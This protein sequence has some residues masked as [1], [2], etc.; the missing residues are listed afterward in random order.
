MDQKL[1]ITIDESL[2]AEH[3]AMAERSLR[4]AIEFL[5]NQPRPKGLPPIENYIPN[6]EEIK[7]V[8]GGDTWAHGLYS[9][10]TM[11]GWCVINVRT[12]GRLVFDSPGAA[13]TIENVDLELATTV[14][15]L[16]MLDGYYYP[17]IDWGRQFHRQL[18]YVDSLAATDGRAKSLLDQ[19]EEH[20][21]QQEQAEKDQLYQQQWA[22]KNRLYF[23]RRKERWQLRL[24]S[25]WCTKWI[26]HPICDVPHDTNRSTQ[27]PTQE[28]FKQ[29]QQPVDL[30]PTQKPQPLELEDI[31]VGDH[32][33]ATSSWQ[34][35][36]DAALNTEESTCDT[37]TICEDHDK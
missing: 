32:A 36:W 28:N 23:D 11:K 10:Q 27:P 37:S 33:A 9:A 1:N 29:F 12:D 7:F 30:P 4:K 18:Q 6:W 24:P 17:N 2:P 34:R 5:D 8:I 31:P 15:N 13:I 21:Q 20:Q 19:L 22:E 14:S 26:D 35:L 25:W 16:G 3:H